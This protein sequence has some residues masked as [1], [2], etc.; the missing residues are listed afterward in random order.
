MSEKKPKKK[1]TAGDIVLSIILVA[2]VCVFCYAGYNLF[3][4]YTEYKKGTDEYNS[5]T[6]MAVTERDPDGEAAGPEAGSELK[7]PMDIDFASL[8]S[9][10]DD[11]VGWIY[12]EAVPDINYPIVHGKDNETYLHRT[13]EKN[14]NFAGTIFVDYENKG[15]FSDCN[16]I[17]YGH[18]MKNGSMFNN[19]KSYTD[20]SFA[21][22]HPYVY[23]YLP[24][25]TVSQY[26]VVVGHIISESSVLY[27]TQIVDTASFVQEMVKTSSIKVDFDQSQVQSVITLSTCTSAGSE[28][29]KRNVVHAIL[30]RKGIDPVKEKMEN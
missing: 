27:S 15:D 7:A 11:V 1:K 28:S 22:E 3:H 25:G 2:A 4:I 29:G 10:N 30:Q 6:Q 23:I 19:I 8:K 26:K 9:V 17:V 20:Q 12:V 13:Y 16:T 18:N 5:I 14:Y 24:D 21:D